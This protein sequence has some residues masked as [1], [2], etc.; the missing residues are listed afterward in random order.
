MGRKKTTK[1]TL[2][3]A[4]FATST[5]HV[6]NNVANST[7]T[8][9]VYNTDS[10][11]WDITL[12]A[13]SGYKF[14]SVSARYLGTT[15]YYHNISFTISENGK[16]ASKTV[17][18]NV[19]ATTNFT[20]TGKTEA[21][22][23]V[24]TITNNITNTTATYT[25][26]N[27]F[28]LTVTANDGYKFETS[29]TATYTN[30]SGETQTDTFLLSS[31]SKSATLTTVAVSSANLQIYIN[32]DV[33]P[34]TIPPTFANNI[35]NTSYTY[36]GSEHQY[37]VKITANI[38]Y[39]FDGAPEAS[40]KGYSSDNPVSVTFALSSDNKA[41]SA[42]LPDVDENETI[43]LTGSTK[44]DG[45]Q[46]TKVVTNITN[47]TPE[48]TLP[49]AIEAG[50]T[51]TV[52]LKANTNTHFETE[53][54]FMWFDK[55]GYLQT[56][57]FTIGDDLKSA[58]GEYINPSYLPASV[59]IYGD[60][61]QDIVIGDNYGAINVYKV[62]RDNL[63]AFSK[64]RFF[65]EAT[66][67][68]ETEFT[69]INLGMYVNRIKRLFFTVPTA[70]SA[71]IKCG[72]YNTGVECEAPETDT[73]T[74]N[75]GSITVPQPNG[76]TTDY[77]SELQLFL[78][79]KGIVSL[80]TEYIGQTISVT[81]I[82]N[83]VT[84]GGIAKVLCGEDVIAIYDVEP[85]EDILYQTNVEELA[86]IGGDAWNEQNLYGLEPYLY[87]KYYDSLNKTE[88]N[89]DYLSAKLGDLRGFCVVDDIKLNTTSQMTVEE[90][91]AI[92]TQLKGGVFVE[93]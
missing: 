21:S 45:S 49:E 33:V 24:P 4:T 50:E 35:P 62:T 28:S 29:P 52:T 53:P 41:A 82:V 63:E 77:Q 6:T 55:S 60:A 30:S 12:S 18:Y 86:T 44:Q 84:G 27:P 66:N 42:V 51:L 91:E 80:P 31:D 11:S 72:N 69:L 76:D 61:Q 74:L 13:N 88:R 25:G 89:N 58:N 56:Q 17:T 70:S 48:G 67:T 68:G 22:G 73:V 16:T 39:V 78:P 92:I 85:N 54:L 7:V 36:S 47:C 79:F 59:T 5:S 1:A 93:A 37:T 81:Y 90:Q 2:E 3:V 64:K 46:T 71:V 75:F 19:D 9:E 65:K 8:G 10:K 32:G 83:I 40:Y 38:G 23:D 43:T 87:M 26:E 34:E 15:G 57:K 14:K 20:L